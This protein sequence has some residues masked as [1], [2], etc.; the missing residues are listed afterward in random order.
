MVGEHRREQLG[1]GQQ[2]LSGHAQRAQRRREGV[3]GGGEHREG[4]LTAEHI[5]QPSSLNRRNQSRER[6]RGHSH[7]D[8]RPRRLNVGRRRGIRLGRF[9]CG[10]CLVGSFGGLVGVVPAGRRHEGKR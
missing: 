4:P 10:W 6:P 2:I 3:L 5:N 1:V 8:N 7:L 9:R